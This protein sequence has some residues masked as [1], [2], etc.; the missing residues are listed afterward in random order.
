[1][2]SVA[3]KSCN[4]RSEVPRGVAEGEGAQPVEASTAAVASH[5]RRRLL[6]LPSSAPRDPC[7]STGQ[8]HMYLIL[9]KR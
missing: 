6:V 9:P 1:M 4:Q 8:K 3:A 2:V 7:L 5:L